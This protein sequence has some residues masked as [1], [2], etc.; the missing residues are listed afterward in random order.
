MTYTA[1]NPHADGSTAS[2]ARPRFLPTSNSE[3][4]DTSS[5]P[6]TTGWREDRCPVVSKQPLHSH[7]AAKMSQHIC[8][9][10]EPILTSHAPSLP[11]EDNRCPAR[12]RFSSPLRNR[13]SPHTGLH[14]GRCNP[15]HERERYTDLVNRQT[16]HFSS[17]GKWGGE[18]ER[19]MKVRRE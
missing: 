1:E 13:I 9:C 19:K 12:E 4:N 17:R 11:A 2:G 16:S 6:T 14:R 8:I 5:A 7:A 10:Q 3:P 15:A 18:S